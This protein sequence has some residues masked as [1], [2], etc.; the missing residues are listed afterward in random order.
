[1]KSLI[2]S[3][4]GSTWFHEDTRAPAVVKKYLLV[5]EF[6]A[7]ITNVLNMIGASFK[8]KDQLQDHQ[9]E[10]LEQ[11]QE[12]DRVLDAIKCGGSNPNGILQ[13]GAFFTMITEYEF[14]FLLHL[15]LKILVMSNEL[16]ASLQRK[17]L[18]PANAFANFDKEKIMI[19]VKHYPDG[20]GESKLRELSYQL[21]T[22]IMHMR[23]CDPI[24][25]N[26]KEI[27]DLTKALVN[28]NLVETYSLAYLLVK[29]MLILSVATATEERVFSSMKHIKNELHSSIGDT[30]L[31]DYLICY[32]E[33]DI[34][35]I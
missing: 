17:N 35:V 8:R 31:S 21:D 6:F 2:L 4:G 27:G 5:D 14:A 18:N 13:A 26:L 15:M 10:M 11:L 12:S 7:I 32:I 23:H 3:R 1:M 33:N 16:S 20:F 25:S 22:F 24:F 28:A 30:F 9:T 19:L 34:F 29:L